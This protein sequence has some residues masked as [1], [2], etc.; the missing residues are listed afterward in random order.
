MRKLT[1]ALCFLACQ[2]AAGQDLMAR[3][4]QLAARRSASALDP[5]TIIQSWVGGT[6][7]NSTYT[8]GPS[9]AAEGDSA[10]VG[11]VLLPSGKVALV[12]RKSDYVG[13]Y[14]P[15]AGT[16]TRGPSIA[17]EGD[18]A[19]YGGVLLPSGKVAL[20][21]FYADYVG[22]VTPAP[23]TTADKTTCESAYLNKF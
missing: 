12:P 19:F 13:I 23:L 15:D 18:V 4:M 9:M 20:V 22:I 8:R 11:G 5:W 1:I 21:P 10:F 7:T 3:N 6:L 14:D 16:Y 17:A 2:C